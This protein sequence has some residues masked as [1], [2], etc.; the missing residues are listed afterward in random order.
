MAVSYVLIGLRYLNA[1][2]RGKQHN[3]KVTNSLLLFAIRLA[4]AIGP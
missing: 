3:A 2:F 1:R 4:M